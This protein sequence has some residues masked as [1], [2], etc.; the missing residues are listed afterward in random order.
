MQGGPVKHMVSLDLRHADSQAL[1]VAVSASQY[2]FGQ[3][4]YQIKASVGMLR[5][6]AEPPLYGQSAKRDSGEISIG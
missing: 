6:G 2:Y 1:A 4:L 3:E 5:V